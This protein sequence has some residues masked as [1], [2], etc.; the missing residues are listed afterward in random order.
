M[1]FSLK[2]IFYNLL[3]LFYVTSNSG[4]HNIFNWFTMNWSFCEAILDFYMREA[5]N[6]K[7]KHKSISHLKNIYMLD[8]RLWRWPNIKPTSGEC[9]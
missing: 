6:L 3:W 2:F 5:R 8:Q 9:I 1:M 7:K 4:A